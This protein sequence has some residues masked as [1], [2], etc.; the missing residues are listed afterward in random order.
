MKCSQIQGVPKNTLQ[1]GVENGREPVSEFFVHFRLKT[2]A[3]F[4]NSTIIEEFRLCL[5][6]TIPDFRVLR[7]RKVR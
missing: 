5:S 1:I 6:E 4:Y 2:L 3:K 7:Y